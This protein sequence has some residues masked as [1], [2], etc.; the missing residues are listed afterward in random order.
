[1]AATQKGHDAFDDLAQAFRCAVHD[2]VVQA[3]TEAL[4]GHSEGAS[5]LDVPA[6]AER[7]AISTAKVKRLIAAGELG[8]VLI[9]RR[10][11]VPAEALAAYVQSLQPEQLRLF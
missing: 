4:S 7:L 8:S 5:L 2:A 11:L 1:M 6:V 3:V 9:G 10:R